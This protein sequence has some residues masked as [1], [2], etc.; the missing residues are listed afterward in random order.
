LP[1][2]CLVTSGKTVGLS[3]CP[4]DGGLSKDR[5]LQTYLLSV[6]LLDRE[7][8]APQFATERINRDDVQT[9]MSKVTAAPNAEFSRRIGPEMPASLSIEMEGGELIKG[10]EGVFDG[11]WATPMFWERVR[12]KFDRLTDGRIDK[13]LG[14]ELAAA[15][16][17]ID[18]IMAR[19]LTAL[20]GRVSPP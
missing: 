13:G 4:H 8:W 7:I 19:D 3:R 1:D 17:D 6:A 14:A 2:T 18:A 20:L 10:E 9:L 12:A 11:F 16:Q 15:A 5:G